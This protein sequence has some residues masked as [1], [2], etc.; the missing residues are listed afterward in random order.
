M[1]KMPPIRTIFFIV[2]FLGTLN[3][4]HNNI[5]SNKYCKRRHKTFLKFFL[6]I[7]TLN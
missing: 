5:N 6:K 3:N 7:S 2:Y 1:A 4:H